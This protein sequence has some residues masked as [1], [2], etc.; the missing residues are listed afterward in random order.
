MHTLHSARTEFPP[1]VPNVLGLL[2]WFLAV[3]ALA[4]AALIALASINQ[5]GSRVE[6]TPAEDVSLELR[7][8]LEPFARNRLPVR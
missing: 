4:F 7:P 1:N 5:A 8:S 2:I 6:Q 3:H